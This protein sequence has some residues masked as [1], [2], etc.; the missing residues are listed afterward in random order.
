MGEHFDQETVFPV[1]AEGIEELCA[2]ADQADAWPSRDL[3]V[4]YL[5]ACDDKES[6]IK[7]TS[8]CW[9]DRGLYENMVDWWSAKFTDKDPSIRP[10]LDRFEQ[11]RIP[12]PQP[13][14]RR[15]TLLAYRPKC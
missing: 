15:R 9:N 13:G 6:L 2:T 8:D 11:Q 4:E 7:A 5:M 3:I 14:N 1:I 10:Y 12:A